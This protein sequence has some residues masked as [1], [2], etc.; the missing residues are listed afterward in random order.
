MTGAK[1]LT[2]LYSTGTSYYPVDKVTLNVYE[3]VDV[4]NNTSHLGFNGYYE[5]YDFDNPVT[6]HQ[7]TYYVEVHIDGEIFKTYRSGLTQDYVMPNN[8]YMVLLFG[9]DE[10][11][12]DDVPIIEHEK[13]G[14]KNIFLEVIAFYD[15]TDLDGNMYQPEVFHVSGRVDLTQIG[16]GVEDFETEDKEA[17]INNTATIKAKLIVKPTSDKEEIILTEN[18][19]IK[20]IIYE[21]ERYVP[22]EGWIG[23]F[24]ARVLEVELQNISEDFNIENRE[25]EF[26][27]GINNKSQNT[28][29]YYSYGTFII[30][31]PEDDEVKDNTKFT[32]MDYTK[33]FNQVFD[34]NFTNNIY[35][36]S[37]TTKITENKTYTPLWLA[38][39]TCAQVGIQFIQE[40]FVNS[41]FI[42]RTNPFQNNETCRDVM[43]QIAKLA[44]GWVRIDWYDRCRIETLSIPENIDIYNTLTTD[45]YFTLETQKEKYG[46]INKVV[47]GM[48]GIDGESVSSPIDET[49][50][51]TYGEHAIYIY[52]NPLLDVTSVRADAVKQGTVLYGLTYTPTKIETIGHPWFKGTELIKIIDPDGNYKITYPFNRQLKYTGHIRSIIESTG[53]TKVEA[54]YA[55]KNEIVRELRN[56]MIRVDKQ[57]G[58]ITD[59]TSRLEVVEDEFGNYYTVEQTDEL[60]NDAKTGLTNTYTTSGGNNI[61]KNTGLYFEEEDGF[62]YWNGPIAVERNVDSASGNSMLLQYGTVTQNVVDL[63]N[64]DYTISF[65]Y[66]KL[67]ELATAS[68]I[69]N[70]I[71]YTLENQG[72]FELPIVVDA[73]V[74]DISFTCDTND[75]Y[76]IW[77]LMCN[78][79]TAS[80][81]W[82]QHANEVRTDMV[83]IS[84]GITIKSSTINTTF[85]A[86]ADGIRIENND[87]KETTN[88]TEQGM[89]TDVAVVRVQGKITGALF[90]RV[91]NQTWINGL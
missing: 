50:V 10:F 74:I 66:N 4:A 89:E 3:N 20:S 49:S 47:F 79:G 65:S 31:K 15:T 11:L 29:N 33:K 58:V 69:V 39:Y 34:S 60:I 27:L 61:F 13:N 22:D 48:E 68:V 55:Y 37:L 21:D 24:V 42:L 54:T 1:L 76:E 28:E 7:G 5:N 51:T 82:S 85:K 62:E 35:T 73:N 36:E 32:A 44:F 88:F 2:T 72:K 71:W 67:N 30:T 25:V 91:G 77:E 86:D 19:S 23:Q 46:P 41:E 78:R 90:N 53:E 87:S 26:Q 17:L 59:H 81:P 80:Q 75:G 38:Q 16:N 63:P 12:G 57:E 64:G 45:E 14:S 83:N 40:S 84:K 43:K 8:S 6:I 52:D 18:N 9:I 70:G 56:A